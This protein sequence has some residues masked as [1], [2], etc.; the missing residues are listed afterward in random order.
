VRREARVSVGPGQVASVVA[1]CERARELVITGGCYADPMWVAELV[2]ARPV[3]IT[4]GDA[5]S[6]W[7]C[8]YRNTSTRQTIEVV[9]EVYCVNA[10]R[11]TRSRRAQRGV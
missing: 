4:D 8:D 1:T 7:R 11:V 6:S 5:A 9:A 2:A 3:G 10:A